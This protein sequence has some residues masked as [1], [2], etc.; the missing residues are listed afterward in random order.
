MSDFFAQQWQLKQNSAPIYYPKLPHFYI[1]G[2][3]L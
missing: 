2:D 3:Y 1:H